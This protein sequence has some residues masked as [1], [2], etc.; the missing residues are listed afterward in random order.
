MGDM[1]GEKDVIFA[2]RKLYFFLLE[3]IS[4]NQTS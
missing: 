2:P 4:G 3:E 1:I